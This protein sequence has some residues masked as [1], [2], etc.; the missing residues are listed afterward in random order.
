MLND[1]VTD[2]YHHFVQSARVPMTLRVGVAGHREHSNIRVDN[3]ELIQTIKQL[4]HLIITQLQRCRAHPHATSLYQDVPPVLRLISSLADGADRLLLESDL[5]DAPYELAAILPFSVEEYANDF[6]EQSQQ[7]FHSLL[8]KAAHG[9]PDSR[10]LELDGDRQHSDFAYRDCAE[11]L[12]RNCDLLVALYDG[13]ERPGYGT[14][15]TVNQALSQKIPVIWI[16][17]EHPNSLYFI[18]PQNGRITQQTLTLEALYDWLGHLLLFDT[19]LSSSESDEQDG[20]TQR[21]LQRFTSFNEEAILALDASLSPDFN[22]SGPIVLDKG[23]RNPLHNGFSVLKRV[24]TS[25]DSID[26]EMT[27]HSEELPTHAQ[28]SPLTNDDDQPIHTAANHA[29]FAAY[30]RADRLASYYAALHR[31][32]FVFIYLLGAGALIVAALAI[33]LSDPAQYGNASVYCAGIEIIL[34]LLIYV[35]FK[36][37]KRQQ[38]HDRWLE[39]RC[40]AEFLRP[41]LYLSFFGSHFPMRRFCDNEEVLSRNLLGHGRPERCWAYLYT[42]TVLR[43]VGFSGYKIN[44]DYLQRALRFTRSQWI[45]QQYRYHSRNALAMN[46]MGRRLAKMSEYLFVATIV[47]VCLKVA[48]G[49]LPARF[50]L[51]SKA[52]GVLAAWFPVLGTTAFAIRNHAEFEISAQRSLSAREILLG[53]NRRLKLL[54]ERPVRLK[55]VDELLRELTAASITETADWLEIYEVKETET[56]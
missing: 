54:G 8:D 49:L 47:V 41:T 14:A 11:A 55:V 37:D 15:W 38:L 9:E 6:S 27:R 48:F 3:D 7:T 5:V 45:S 23:G 28:I 35:L 16:D 21:I 34:L 18:Q 33:A 26:K 32:T 39:Y 1:D 29:Y 40:I 24:F 56:V 2:S 12:V 13:K 36:R 19:I 25:N 30:L 50:Y 4:Y 53:Y 10:V 52:C 46:L 22:E 20:L 51:A 31:S 17:S 43:W 44:D 42:E